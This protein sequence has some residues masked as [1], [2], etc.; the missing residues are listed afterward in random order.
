MQLARGTDCLAWYHKATIT[1]PTIPQSLVWLVSLVEDN[2]NFLEIGQS[3][4]DMFIVN[5]S[6]KQ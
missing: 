4:D 3:P 6:R 2:I 5:T 1:N